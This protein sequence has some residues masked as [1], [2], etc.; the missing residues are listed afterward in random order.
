MMLRRPNA[1]DKGPA[2]KVPAPMPMTKE[3][4]I[5]CALLGASGLSSAAISG[6]AGSIA[7]IE[8]AMVANIT[9]ISAMN[10]PWL[11]RLGAAAAVSVI[12]A[13]SA[14]R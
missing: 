12:P 8:K 7:S 14:V 6:R 3:V 5:S 1:S 10:S 11:R 2:T 13:P 4:R 9:P